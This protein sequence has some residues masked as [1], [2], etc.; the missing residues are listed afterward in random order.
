MCRLN[1]KNQ[2]LLDLK[3]NQ[4]IKKQ[5]TITQSWIFLFA[6]P[7]AVFALNSVGRSFPGRLLFIYFTSDCSIFLFD[8]YTFFSAVFTASK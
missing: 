7:A 1:N 2:L 6:P 3:K 5:D 4:Q 8:Q